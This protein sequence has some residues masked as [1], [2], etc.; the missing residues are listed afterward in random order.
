MAL[1]RIVPQILILQRQDSLQ[2]IAAMT[3]SERDSY[4]KKML[5]A[6]RKQQGL[7]E[8]ENNGGSGGSGFTTNNANANMFNTGA[9]GEWYFYNQAIK[10][11]GYNDFKSRW[12]NRPNVDNWEVQ[13]LINKQITGLTPASNL[14]LNGAETRQPVAPAPRANHHDIFNG[15]SSA[16]TGE[17]GEVK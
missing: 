12:G 2:R 11:K 1:S 9:A 13:S 17:N 5:R 3:P 10:A 15:S 8:E 16:H 7:A 14:R 4:I 6:Y